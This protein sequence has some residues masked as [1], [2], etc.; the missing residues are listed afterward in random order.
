MSDVINFIKNTFTKKEK[1]PTECEKLRDQYCATRFIDPKNYPTVIG[2]DGKCN[3]TEQ[4]GKVNYDPYTPGKYTQN[5]GEE[6]G[7]KKRK[8]AKKSKK[9]TK[10]SKKSKKSR[11]ARRKSKK[12]RK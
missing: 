11:K 9:S 8:S 6:F 1:E 7:G 10:K 3:F 12:S 5:S 2:E 4:D